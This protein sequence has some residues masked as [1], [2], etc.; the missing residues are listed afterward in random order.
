MTV[1]Y[2]GSLPVSAVN[3]GLSASLPALQLEVDQLGLDISGLVPAIAAKIEVATN[4]PPSPFFGEAI[5]GHLD[6]EAITEQL[7]PLS[8]VSVAA[9]ANADLAVELGLVELK[10]RDARRVI[11]ALLVDPHTA[12]VARLALDATRAASELEHAPKD[13]CAI[14]LEPMG[15][16]A[17]RKVARHDSADTAVGIVP[18]LL[19]LCTSTILIFWMSI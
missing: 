10:P 2:V 5:S 4:F 17:S 11:E 7:N 19:T 8:W 18:R 3:V 16:G 15:E 6:L 9:D 1:S 13:V 14:A 12:K